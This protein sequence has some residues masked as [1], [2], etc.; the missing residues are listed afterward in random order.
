MPKYDD[1]HVEFPNTGPGSLHQSAGEDKQDLIIAAGKELGFLCN[2][3]FDGTLVPAWDFKTRQETIAFLRGGNDRMLGLSQAR[4]KWGMFQGG[5]FQTEGSAGYD[6]EL[7]GISIRGGQ[8][9]AAI[10]FSTLYD[11]TGGVGGG[12]AQETFIFTDRHLGLDKADLILSTDRGLR[13]ENLEKKQVDFQGQP[14]TVFAPHEE[15]AQLLLSKTSGDDT[16][17]TQLRLGLGS[18]A[19]DDMGIEVQRFQKVGEEVKERVQI[20]GNVYVGQDELKDDCLD[21]SDLYLRRNFSLRFC[22]HAPGTVFSDAAVES[23]VVGELKSDETGDMGFKCGLQAHVYEDDGNGLDWQFRNKLYDVLFIG[24]IQKDCSETLPPEPTVVDPEKGDSKHYDD[25]FLFSATDFYLRGAN[26]LYL[27][28]YHSKKWV[29]KDDP[30]NFSKLYAGAAIWH[31]EGAKPAGEGQGVQEGKLYIGGQGNWGDK[32]D[33]NVVINTKR[34]IQDVTEPREDQ[35]YYYEC[36]LEG[37]GGGEPGDHNHDLVYA[38]KTDLALYAKKTDLDAYA[39]LNHVH[40]E[41]AEKVTILGPGDLNTPTGKIENAQDLAPWTQ[42]GHMVFGEIHHPPPDPGAPIAW[43]DW[44]LL[45]FAN[46]EWYGASMN[47]EP[48]N[49]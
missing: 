45:I 19:A 4:L 47:L 15:A 5:G 21:G 12:P 3:N 29:A 13:W 49:M 48:F 42:E 26:K 8:D 41:F 31:D 24:R 23:N 16:E 18:G 25:P 40:N 1:R 10:A 17:V 14:M 33:V 32:T 6:Q 20:N 35:I 39:P 27:S 30:A 34:H 2:I 36:S 22:L 38:K 9:E 44:Q 43:H 11:A 28:G 46:G 37:A 7:G